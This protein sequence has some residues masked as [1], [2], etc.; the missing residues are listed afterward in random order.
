MEGLISRL[1]LICKCFSCNDFGL[2]NSDKYK[3]LWGGGDFSNKA[4]MKAQG[5]IIFILCVCCNDIGQD[6]MDR[7]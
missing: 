4:V 1:Y 2:I 3:G 5:M 6:T 7:G